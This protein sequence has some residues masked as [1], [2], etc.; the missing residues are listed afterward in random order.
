[1]INIRLFVFVA[2]LLNLSSCAGLHIKVWRSEVV[3]YGN[4]QKM[5]FHEIKVMD[6]G[7]IRCYSG[8]DSWYGFPADSVTT[9]YTYE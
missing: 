2:L 6:D 8:S 4:N 1:M 9:T 7:S 5:S 3:T